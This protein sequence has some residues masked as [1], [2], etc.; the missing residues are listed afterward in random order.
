MHYFIPSVTQLIDKTFDSRVIIIIIIFTEFLSWK[1]F[2]L[3]QLE[4]R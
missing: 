2:I 3:L 1:R 4:G